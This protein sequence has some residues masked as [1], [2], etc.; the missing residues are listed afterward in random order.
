MDFCGLSDN[1]INDAEKCGSYDKNIPLQYRVIMKLLSD[2]NYSKA[3]EIISN[4]KEYFENEYTYLILDTAVEMSLNTVVDENGRLYET[5]LY[6]GNNHV[7]RPTSETVK[8]IEYL[9]NNCADSNLP[10]EFNQLKH[11][12]DVER[13]GSQQCQC[14]FDCSEIIQLLSKYM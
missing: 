4:N 14:K 2:K 13:D 12:T 3:K 11:I 5:G 8:F 7:F 10:K 9:L 6:L 1:F